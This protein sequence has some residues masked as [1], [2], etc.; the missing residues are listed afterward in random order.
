MV[1][2]VQMRVRLL[3]LLEHFPAQHFGHQY[4]Q[5]RA[6]N[7]HDLSLDRIDDPFGPIE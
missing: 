2:H 1:V 6:V 3:D 7:V 5:P 4:R